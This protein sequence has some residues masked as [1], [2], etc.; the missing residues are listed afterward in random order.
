[1]REFTHGI[2]ILNDSFSNQV[3]VKLPGGPYHHINGVQDPTVNNGMDVG[4]VLPSIDAKDGV[5]LLR[6]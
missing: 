4:S 2:V 6:D 5:V 3:N 1:M